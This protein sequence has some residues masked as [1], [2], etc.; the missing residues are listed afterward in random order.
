MHAALGSSF[1]TQIEIRTKEYKRVKG[2]VSV[3]NFP[4]LRQL[5]SLMCCSMTLQLHEIKFNSVG[6]IASTL[7]LGLFLG[8]Q[9]IIQSSSAVLG[10]GGY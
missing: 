6:T 10:C 7:T 9:Y 4:N 3:Q 2:K 5:N 1:N 8:K